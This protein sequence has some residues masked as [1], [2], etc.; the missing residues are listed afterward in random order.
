MWERGAGEPADMWKR[1]I[2]FNPTRLHH[3][4]VGVL[5][6]RVKFSRCGLRLCPNGPKG[7]ENN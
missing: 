2:S 4:Q 3:R 1:L 6:V 7:G 5:F